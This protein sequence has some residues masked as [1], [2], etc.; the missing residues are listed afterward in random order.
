VSA[1]V[2]RSHGKRAW[3]VALRLSIALSLRPISTLFPLFTE[4]PPI[5]LS[6]TPTIHT[7]S[8]FCAYI[9]PFICYF[10]GSYSTFFTHIP[11]PWGSLISS[12][13][14][15]PSLCSHRRTRFAK[16]FRR[17]QLRQNRLPTPR[18]PGPLESNPRRSDLERLMRPDLSRVIPMPAPLND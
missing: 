10:F 7:P 12:R 14:E 3:R 15:G 16:L 9:S 18:N 1:V 11:S 13:M 8:C 6:S 17:D 4:A 5:F 2:P